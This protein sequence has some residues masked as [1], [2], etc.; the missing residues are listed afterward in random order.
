MLNA[1]PKAWNSVVI[2]TGQHYD[3][4]MSKNLFRELNI[5]EP[6]YNLNVRSG[7]TKDQVSEITDRLLT[8]LK[9][10]SP[11]IIIIFGDTN[12]T[13]AGARAGSTTEIPIG[14]VEA[15]LRSWNLD[16]PEEYNR[17]ESDHLSKWL[18]APTTTAMINLEKEGMSEK[19]YLTGDVMVDAL[20]QNLILANNSSILRTLEI[21]QESYYL[22]TLHR[23]YNV[24]NIAR[25]KLIIDQIKQLDRKIIFPIHPRT[26]VELEKSHIYVDDPIIPIKAVGYIDFLALEA[27][28][29]KIITDSGGIQKEAFILKKT[30]I[31]IRF[32]TEWMETITAG[33]N[34][35]VFPNDVNLA[36]K[37]MRFEP[38]EKQPSIFGNNASSNIFSIL[39]NSI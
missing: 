39:L 11:D 4:N 20:N 3:D 6:Q 32:E 8:V 19:A 7:L 1:Q 28:A 15:G 27:N 22:L 23:N 2:H 37:I 36:Q 35:L 31:T 10:E 16:M 12:S 13:L 21:E 30:C 29:N 25:L 33:W 26:K 18:F 14:H 38:S 17:V 34:K 5:P 24:D 9:K